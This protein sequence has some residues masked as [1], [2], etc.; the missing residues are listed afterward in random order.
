NHPSFVGVGFY[1]VVVF[2]GGGPPP[3]LTR[4]I[5]RKLIAQQYG[6]IIKYTAVLKT[7]IAEC[8]RDK[9]EG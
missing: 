2:G 1:F 7:G 9:T 6:E 8:L 3:P 4:G 5:D